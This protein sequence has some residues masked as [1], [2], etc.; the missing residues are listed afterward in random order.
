MFPKGKAEK[1]GYMFT[2]AFTL[3]TNPISVYNEAPAYWP[4]SIRVS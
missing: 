3:L 2:Y 4:G 1:E